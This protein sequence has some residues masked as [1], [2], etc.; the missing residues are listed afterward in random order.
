VQS[1]NRAH[2]WWSGLPKEQH[3]S[4]DGKAD[5]DKDNGRDWVNTGNV[6][7][8]G[9]APEDFAAAR[10][11]VSENVISVTPQQKLTIGLLGPAAGNAHVFLPRPALPSTASVMPQEG[12]PAQN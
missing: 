11:F 10:R 3:D 12:R 5:C 4:V 1:R 6:S 9:Q 7:R 8:K 2:R